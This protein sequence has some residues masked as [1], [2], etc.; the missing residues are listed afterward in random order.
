MKKYRNKII[1]INECRLSDR[2]LLEEIKK[3]N[4]V[5]GN[6]WMNKVEK[7]Y[8]KDMLRETIQCRFIKHL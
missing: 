4:P 1:D 2:Y 8:L 3:F 7:E 6:G 5:Y